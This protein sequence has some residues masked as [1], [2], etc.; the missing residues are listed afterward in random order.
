MEDEMD[1]DHIPR[2]APKNMLRGLKLR[3][4]VQLRNN[5]FSQDRKSFSIKRLERGT[6]GRVSR[7]YDMGRRCKEHRFLIDIRIPGHPVVNFYAEELTR[8]RA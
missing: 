2:S 5:D 3:G 6:V 7:I 4:L 1:I 8:V